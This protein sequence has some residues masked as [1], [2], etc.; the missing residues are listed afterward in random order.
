MPAA[1]MARVN[2]FASSVSA[3]VGRPPIIASRFCTSAGSPTE[4]SSMTT[5]ETE[6]SNSLRRFAHH[7]WA[8]CWCPATITSRL[9]RATPAAL[10]PLFIPGWAIHAGNRDVV[11]AE[12]DAQDR[13]V[14]DQMVEDEAPN[15]GRSRHG[16]ER[17]SRPEQRPRLR[18]LVFPHG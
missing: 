5:W 14:V 17:C 15:H 18:H 11:Q 6:H 8:V 12:I 1:M 10:R 16:E 13:T 2:A 7:S 4:A 3:R 9:G